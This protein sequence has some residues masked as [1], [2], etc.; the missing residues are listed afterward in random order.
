MKE[1]RGFYGD[2][3]EQVTVKAN[4]RM[5]KRAVVSQLD[6]LGYLRGQMAG[7]D[8]DAFRI[9]LK[10]LV[11]K[12]ADVL[13]NQVA[14]LLPDIALND[15][16]DFVTL[17]NTLVD[18][19]PD[20]VLLGPCKVSQVFPDLQ[21]KTQEIEDKLTMLVGAKDQLCPAGFSRGDNLGRQPTK[22]GA[23][24]VAEGQL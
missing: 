23:R 7:E 1:A 15:P 6:L 24:L 4:A 14:P 18:K 5:L 21:Q 10:T 2:M 11:E 20:I 22:V 17:T 8:F 16:S 12:V 3:H 13:T 9:D 19:A